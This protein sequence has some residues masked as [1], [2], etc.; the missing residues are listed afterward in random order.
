MGSRVLDTKRV[1]TLWIQRGLTLGAFQG[2]DQGFSG[3]KKAGVS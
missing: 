2:K 1:S 3:M